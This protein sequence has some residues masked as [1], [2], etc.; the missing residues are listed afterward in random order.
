M[1]YQ[2]CE[3]GPIFPPTTSR[4]EGTLKKRKRGIR[5]DDLMSTMKI[6]ANALTAHIGKSNDQMIC[7][8]VRS[9][10]E[11]DKPKKDNRHMLN[12]ELKKVE[13]LTKS[14]RQKTAL[15]LIRNSDLLDYF[16]T[17]DDD[18]DKEI[19]IKELLSEK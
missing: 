5:E 6:M 12:E 8:F 11:V 7:E 3:D 15:K 17:L 16:F 13:G 18:D 4:G 9:S 19:F 10:T 14:A 2:N 1:A